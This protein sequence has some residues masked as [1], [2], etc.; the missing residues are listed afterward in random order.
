ML[1][2]CGETDFRMLLNDENVDICNMYDKILGGHLLFRFVK[3]LNSL[4]Y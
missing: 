1:V 3:D 2:I 4:N